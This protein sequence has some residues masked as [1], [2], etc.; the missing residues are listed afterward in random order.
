[1]ERCVR[2]IEQDQDQSFIEEKESETEDKDLLE[3]LKDKDEALLIVRL[4]FL[5][6]RHL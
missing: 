6:K 5:I 3:R 4:N 1:M 2:M